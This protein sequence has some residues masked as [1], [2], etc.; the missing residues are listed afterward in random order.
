M[1]S[2][3]KRITKLIK[4]YIISYEMNTIHKIILFRYIDDMILDIVNVISSLALDCCADEFVYKDGNIFILIKNHVYM[5]S[6]HCQGIFTKNVGSIEPRLFVLRNPHMYLGEDKQIDQI[7]MHLIDNAIEASIRNNSPFIKISITSD[8][9]CVKNNGCIPIE[10]K[11]GRLLPEIIFE[12]FYSSNNYGEINSHNGMGGKLANIFSNVFIVTICDH[13][14]KLKYI[15]VW[16]RNMAYK[17]DA[18]IEAYSGNT[19]TI[20]VTCKL[21]FNRFNR[22]CYTEDDIQ[23][24]KNK[25]NTGIKNIVIIEDK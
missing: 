2:N 6:K 21:D 23:Q 5:F 14:R 4:I 1:G 3:P 24:V 17:S 15:Q 18:I 25:F 16:F 22:T 9:I 19:S 11:Q 20:E 10:Y 12:T 7:H 13:V 8:S